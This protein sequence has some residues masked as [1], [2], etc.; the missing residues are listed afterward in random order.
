M[1][2]DVVIVCGLATGPSVVGSVRRRCSKCRAEIWVAPS[3]LRRFGTD[4]PP[5]M[6]TTCVGEGLVGHDE[7]KVAPITADQLEELR[8]IPRPS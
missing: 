1:I 5:L 2:G 7:V 8:Q 3:T 4:L 6:C